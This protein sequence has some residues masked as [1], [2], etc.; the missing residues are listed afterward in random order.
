MLHVDDMLLIGNYISF[1]DMIK[2]FIENSFSM[3]YLGKASYWASKSIKAP[4]TAEPKHIDNILKW[5]GKK[6]QEVFLTRSHGMF[7][8]DSVSFDI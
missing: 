8:Q 6:C 3:E 1:L 2:D 4:N 7:E 5:F